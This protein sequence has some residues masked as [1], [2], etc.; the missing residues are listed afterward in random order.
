MSDQT[1][2][3]HLLQTFHEGKRFE[4]ALPG[5]QSFGLNGDDVGVL[6][7]NPSSE[8]FAWML[9]GAGDAPVSLS[10]T[11][12]PPGA[13]LPPRR[14]GQRGFFGWLRGDTAIEGLGVFTSADVFELHGVQFAVLAEPLRPI[15]FGD[16]VEVR[17]LAL[18]CTSV[19]H[20]LTVRI[21][22]QQGLVQSPKTYVLA[23]DSGVISMA[24][25]PLRLCPS[26]S[27]VV[28]LDPVFDVDEVSAMRLL[29]F[30]ARPY[31][32]PV[33]ELLAVVAGVTVVAAAAGLTPVYLVSK[34]S[35]GSPDPIRLR[36]DLVQPLV[37]SPSRPPVLWRL[38]NL[39]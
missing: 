5:L 37:A 36:P 23:L 31:T 27:G 34:G 35:G 19:P 32:K 11:E 21:T 16:L 29:N 1:A 13:A 24:T 15:V 14:A 3:S 30:A 12:P 8:L 28:R 33:Q 22:A 2:W 20:F 18:N 17:L 4:D 7:N 26:S 10:A 38:A 6:L 9:D 39:R 25:L